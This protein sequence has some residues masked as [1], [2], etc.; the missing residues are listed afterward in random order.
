MPGPAC[1]AYDSSMSRSAM[2]ILDANANRAREA[3]RVMED[4]SRF[5]VD[6]A[7]VCVRLKSIRHDLRA[8][9]D[10]LGPGVLEANRDVAGDVGTTLKTD[11][12]GNRAS[13]AAVVIAAGKRLGESL[14]SIEE[15]LKT[16]DAG[17]AAAVESL[18]Y[19]AYDAEQRLQRRLGTAIAPQWRL[20]VLITESLCARPWLDVLDAALEGGA[21][22]IQLR[23]KNLEDGRLLGR[24]TVVVERCRAAGAASIINDRADVALL[25]GADGVHL[26]QSDLPVGHVRRLVGRQ[27][28]IGVSTASMAQ[29]EAA[30]KAGADYCGVG[31]MFHTTTKDKPQL[32]GPAYLR[33]YLARVPLPHLAIGGINDRNVGELLDAGVAGVAVSS[34]VCACDEPAAAVRRLCAALARA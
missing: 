26:G 10:R 25:V 28:L 19:R 20:C 33:E 2:R 30:A 9:L 14:R 18:R 6:D 8:A 21:D 11:A 4:Y 24:A 32:A 7:D 1:I 16:M 34:Y 3:L 27:L 17:A 23:E 22:C 12:E 31:P 13:V 15:Y 29:A 5:I